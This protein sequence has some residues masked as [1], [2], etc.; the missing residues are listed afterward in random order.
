M[1]VIFSFL[2]LALF[3]LCIMVIYTDFKDAEISQLTCIRIEPQQV[4]CQLTRRQ[5]LGLLQT[6][7]Q[8]LENVRT[9]RVNPE[10]IDESVIYR[11]VLVT[12][13]QE[14]SWIAQAYPPK[15]DADSVGAQVKRFL[16]L[17]KE[18]RREWFADNRRHKLGRIGL[19]LILS[20]ISLL[21]LPFPQ[22]K[23]TITKH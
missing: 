16:T 17:G 20:L 10:T 3:S 18:N 7:N 15:S 19:M 8:T 12:P 1:K 13:Q 4:N 21:F 23:L 2:S 5:F 22:K 11:L 6:E 14:V 9:L